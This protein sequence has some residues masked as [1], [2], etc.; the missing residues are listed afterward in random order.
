M[1]GYDKIKPA[2]AIR[3]LG[4]LMGLLA[5]SF[6]GP[7]AQT[8]TVS[9]PVSVQVPSL[10]GQAPAAPT[11]APAPAPPPPDPLGRSTPHGCVLGFLRA[12]EEQDYNRA[13][14]YLDSKLPEQQVEQL[15][16][17]LK[18]LL[19]LGTSTNLE[20]ISRQPEGNLD[21]ELRVSREKIGAVTTPLGQID[22]LLDRITRPNQ[23][24]IW[25]FSPE[26]LDRVPSFY[27]ST[28]HLDPSRYFPACRE[29]MCGFLRGKPHA[30]RSARK[31]P[32]EI[33]VRS[34]P[35]AKPL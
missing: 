33:R 19:D 29:A 2:S 31:D 23:T 18:A 34:T 28:Q 6:G 7:G 4:V 32:Q 20:A 13:G 30:V 15:A 27:A 24:S 1:M 8:Q 12:A 3:T 26:T 10:A 17:E 5:T 21:D 35:I 25:L 11:P 16:L 22:I 9:P 14:K